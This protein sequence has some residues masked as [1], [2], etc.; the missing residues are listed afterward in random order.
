MCSCVVKKTPLVATIALVALAM[1]GPAAAADAVTAPKA[2]AGSLPYDWAGFYVGGHVGYGPGHTRDTVWDPT[3]ITGT[4]SFG[5]LMAGLHAGYNHVLPSRILLG[6]EG[7]ITVPNYLDSSPLMASVPRPD[8]N[9]IQQLDY[10][11]TVRGR[12]GYVWAPW[13]IY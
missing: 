9:L 4:N 7:D 2:P 6:V 10:V 11:G 12:A 3:P 1:H 8:G 13:M 5:G